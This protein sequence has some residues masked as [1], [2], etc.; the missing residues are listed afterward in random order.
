MVAVVADKGIATTYKMSGPSGYKPAWEVG[1][2]FDVPPPRIEL[3]KSRTP[4]KSR[5]NGPDTGV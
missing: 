5:V 2:V 1:I 4:V 3:P